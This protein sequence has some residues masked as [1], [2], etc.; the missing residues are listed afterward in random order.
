MVFTARELQVKCIK[1]NR[2]LFA[3][4]IDLKNAFDSVNRSA[5]WL[6][7]KKLGCPNKLVTI[8][9]QLHDGMTA[10]IS[11]DGKICRQVEVT[12]G[13][14]QGCVIAPILF[15]LFF[16]E[17]LK[18]ALIDIN[19]GIYMRFRTDGDLFNLARLKAQAK[20]KARHTTIRDL[21][22]AD[23]CGLFARTQEV[24]QNLVNRFASAAQSVGLTISKKRQKCSTNVHRERSTF[25]QKLTLVVPS[26]PLRQHS[27]I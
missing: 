8:I 23:D 1:Q 18:K 15:L 9:R 12:A 17:M 10:Q 24:R 22:F 13:V 6:I 21:L 3:V 11:A 14:K 20:A 16:A 27:H 25:L 26:Q 7:L 4:F 5:L 2:S 19:D